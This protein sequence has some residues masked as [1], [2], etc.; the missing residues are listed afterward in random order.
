MKKGSKRRSITYRFITN[1]LRFKHT[2]RTLSPCR[3][4]RPNAVR[5]REAP[6]AEFCQ[7]KSRTP[8]DCRRCGACK[9]GGSIPEGIVGFP[10]T[11]SLCRLACPNAVRDRE[12]QFSLQPESLPHPSLCRLACPNAV[13]D[14]EAQFSLQPESLPHPS[15]CR[16][17]C[18][19]AVRDREAQYAP[20]SNDQHNY[21]QHTINIQLSYT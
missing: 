16:L 8:R 4:A 21:P 18:P 1:S 11:P 3:L 15:L 13:R 6:L 9:G 19:N 14:R 2:L 20:R 7:L 5:D 12:A 17:A 10:G